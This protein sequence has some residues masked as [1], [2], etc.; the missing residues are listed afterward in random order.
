MEFALIEG[1]MYVAMC[2]PGVSSVFDHFTVV[3]VPLR[4]RQRGAVVP[5]HSRP[6][7]DDKR[8]SLDLL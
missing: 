1:V 8:L 2:G 7:S 6:L 4:V 5:L 3:T